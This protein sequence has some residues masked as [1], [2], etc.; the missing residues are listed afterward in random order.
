MTI[1]T[2]AI[3]AILELTKRQR[4]ILN[5]LSSDELDRIVR[6]LKSEEVAVINSHGREAQIEYILANTKPESEK[7][8]PRVSR[9]LI[10][11]SCG[12]VESIRADGPVETLIIDH[13]ETDDEQQKQVRTINGKETYLWISN[14]DE[15]V[16]PSML[17]PYF[18][19]A[20]E[21]RKEVLNGDD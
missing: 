9:V 15:I 1:P 16:E 21:V 6:N 10:D 7:P 12:V 4:A 20:K 5:S 14:V 18:E 13:D 3:F 19:A 2:I 11:L 17:D 8:T